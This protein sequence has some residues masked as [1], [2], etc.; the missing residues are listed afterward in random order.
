MCQVPLRK[1][2]CCSL[3]LSPLRSFFFLDLKELYVLYAKWPNEYFTFLVLNKILNYLLISS[4][5][6]VCCLETAYFSFCDC[7][8][9]SPQ[10]W[11]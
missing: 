5:I 11:R 10:A 3:D 6:E 2:G 9:D 8:S 1:A 4:A 7:R